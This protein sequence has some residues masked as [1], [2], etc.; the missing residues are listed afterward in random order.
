MPG[1]R[2][3]VIVTGNEMPPSGRRWGAYK[4]ADR[5]LNLGR[6]QSQRKQDRKEMKAGKTLS[7]RGYTIKHC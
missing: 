2:V 7:I 3:A 1:P 6:T 4:T 5:D